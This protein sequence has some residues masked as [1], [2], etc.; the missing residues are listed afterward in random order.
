METSANGHRKKYIL[1]EISYSKLPKDLTDMVAERAYKFV[2]NAD[3]KGDVTAT[4]LTEEQVASIIQ[5]HTD[6]EE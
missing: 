6:E 4:E 2:K 3:G 5:T 1:L